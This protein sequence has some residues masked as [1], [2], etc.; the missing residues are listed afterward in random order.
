M[1]STR[2]EATQCSGLQRSVDDNCS[3]HHHGSSAHLAR[4]AVAN[5]WPRRAQPCRQTHSCM[6]V[7]RS[8]RGVDLRC[9]GVVSE[10]IGL[11]LSPHPAVCKRLYRDGLR[12]HGMGACCAFALFSLFISCGRRLELT[13]IDGRSCFGGGTGG[14]VMVDVSSGRLVA[15]RSGSQIRLSIVR[16]AG[17]LCCSVGEEVCAPQRTRSN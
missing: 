9:C 5:P 12:H 10:L 16:A 2:I 11:V 14:I 17:A 4:V 3:R 13:S 8:G 1:D 15:A 7:D 6:D